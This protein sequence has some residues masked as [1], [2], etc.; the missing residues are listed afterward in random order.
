MK[1]VQP[2]TFLTWVEA[3]ASFIIPYSI[4]KLFSW[5][6]HNERF[7]KRWRDIKSKPT[8]ANQPT[9]CQLL[10]Q[11]HATGKDSEQQLQRSLND[12]LDIICQQVGHN[13]DL[14]MRPFGFCKHNAMLLY[15][16]C[17]ADK[18]VINQFVLEP[19]MRAEASDIGA[20]VM[21]GDQLARSL[22]NT[23]IPLSEI[24]DTNDIKHLVTCLLTGSSI[25][26]IDGSATAIVLGTKAKL[27]RSIEDPP[28]EPLVRGPRLGFI[29][30]LRA[31]TTILRDRINDPNFT[32]SG[33]ELGE[34]NRKK[35]ALFYIK[36]IAEPDL[37]EEVKRRID[38]I[39]A[40]DIPETGYIEQWIEDNYLSPFPQ[41]QNT[42]RPDRVIAAL[43][44]GRVAIMV[45]GSPFA[46]IAPVTFNMMLQTPE[47][48]YDRWLPG[49]LT[50]MLRYLAAFVALFG[51]AIYIAFISFHQGLIPTKLAIS[52][53]GTREGVPFPP[54]VESLM[55]EISIEVL[56][57]AGL[58]LPVPVG[59]VV[60]VGGLVV[61]TA[62]VEAHL[63]SP[64]MIIVVALTAISS[65]TIPQ[66]VLSISIRM[67]RFLVMFCAATLGLYG[68]IM[69]FI[70]LT[71]HVVKLKSFGVPYVSPAATFRT[72]DWEDFIVRFPIF[73]MVMRPKMLK[74][75]NRDRQ[76]PSPGDKSD[77]G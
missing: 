17:L 77:K 14:Y 18:A 8:V 15:M 50:R 73:K 7:M 38:T 27:M 55:M 12:N 10:H 46:L 13:T 69:F 19:L 75:K 70:V 59:S 34:R 41:L 24:E 20:D 60:L 26:L 49:S 64:I 72:N 30:S 40:D 4:Y 44:E 25:L 35:V 61:G 65:F 3:L 48:Y 66:Y 29:E 47:D 5:L 2:P 56:R 74:S 23:W 71:A 6:S 52:M 28:S 1:Y 39:Q 33:F 62:A 9:Q 58:R 54:L 16:D 36:D 45:D 76:P 53:S 37:V 42:E 51:P 63:V 57:E 31:N 67:L 22:K 21:N 68:V 32:V 11:P 43:L